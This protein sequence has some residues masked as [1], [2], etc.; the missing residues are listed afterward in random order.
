MGRAASRRSPVASGETLEALGL[1]V[2][3]GEFPA[4]R[5]VDV[6]FGVGEFAAIIGPN[7]AG[8]STLLRALLGLN[9]VEAGEVRLLGR[10]L[11][12][13]SRPERAR[14][15]AYLAQDEGLPEGARVR[16]V[17]A[18]GRG[19]GEWRWG[20]IPTRPWTGADEDAVTE[21]MT[22]TDTLRFAERRVT[23]LSGG[24]RQ[25]VSLAR[26]L[27]AG[28]RF[29]LL[30]EPTNH[31]DLAYGLDVIRHVRAEAARGLGV[32]AVLHD[33]NLAARAQ[34]LVLLHAGQ[35][36]AQ[37]TPEEVLTPEH[38]HAAYGVRVRI[39]RDAGRLL[40]VPED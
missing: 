38:L 1:H 29:L 17:V 33:L 32:V 13:W 19:A 11:R 36:V 18:L 37:G 40:V 10:S 31:L 25:R 21:A 3:A 34:R 8:K 12:T 7:G 20:L 9:P 28:P 30:D 16:D 35:V 6:A 23:E 26:A 15:V 2:R 27:A 14:T 22:R 4:V 39:L 24:E 5:G